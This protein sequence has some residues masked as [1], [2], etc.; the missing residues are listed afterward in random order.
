M[1]RFSGLSFVD[2]KVIAII[3][4][5]PNNS[6]TTTQLANELGADCGY[7]N[8]YLQRLKRAGLVEV[9]DQ[10]KQPHTWGFKK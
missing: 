3:E 4:R 6:I 5:A 1:P 10:R 8:V 7:S 9:K 2:R